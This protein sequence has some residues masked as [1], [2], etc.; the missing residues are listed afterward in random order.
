MP[1]AE[2][3]P[4]FDAMS[5]EEIMAWMESLAKRQGA[6]EGFTTAADVDIAEVDPTSVEIDEPGYVPYGKDPKKWAEE[7]AA[8]KAAKAASPPTV[9]APQ[10]ARPAAPAP[11]QPLPPVQPIRPAA[12][13]S[14]PPAPAQPQRPAAQ[15]PT[16]SKPAEPEAPLGQNT[17]SWLESLAADQGGDLPELDLSA[18]AADIT[19]ATPAPT[20]KPAVNPMDWLESLT[21]GQEAETEAAESVEPAAVADPFASGVDPMSW[22]ESVARRQGGRSEELTTE[23]NLNVPEPADAGQIEGPG[24]TP[25]SFDTMGLGT[26]P[27]EEGQPAETRPPEVEAEPAALEDPSAWLDSL[28]SSQGFAPEVARSISAEPEPSFSDDEIQTALDRGEDIPHDQM[29]LWMSRQ[30]EMG[31]MREEPEAEYDPDAPAVPAELPDWLIEQVGASR[32]PEDVVKPPPPQQPALIDL[33]TEPPPATDIPDWLKDETPAESDLDDIFAATQEEPEVVDAV[34]SS[35]EPEVDVQDTW[36]EALE[37]ERQQDVSELPDWYVQNISDPA[38]RAAVDRRVFAES[39][40]EEEPLEEAVLLP[41]DDLP[42]G[43]PEDIPD[44]LQGVVSEEALPELAPAEEMPDWLRAEVG[45]PPVEEMPAEVVIEPAADIPDWL[46]SVDVDE[47]PDWLKETISPPAAAV[48]PA[49]PPAPVTVVPM[50]PV[51]SQPI[52]PPSP[53]TPP[54]FAPQPVAAREEASATLSEARAS[55][56]GGDFDSGLRHYEAL[57]RANVDLDSVSDD[58]S[59][60][61]EKYKTNPAIFRVLGDSLMRQGKLQAAL[62]TYR[63]AL[64]QL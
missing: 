49:P 3:T 17:M 29:E 20:A 27:P 6:D 24:Y 30:L 14:Q 45:A 42:E 8:R 47:V 64:N 54:V 51:V 55:M 11:S 13:V 62:D 41:E 28:A 50:Q 37:Y 9:T 23:A 18:L 61:A 33:I 40:E 38:R 7:E 34:V 22:L 4:N 52:V 12:Q 53:A 39:A 10:P 46:K 5:P 19:P 43:Q 58:L 36:A 16:P 15:V 1:P 21:Q 63:K 59:S 35:A 31:A 56:S 32:P 44:W 26:R 2:N 60:L 57:V 25:Y 48:E